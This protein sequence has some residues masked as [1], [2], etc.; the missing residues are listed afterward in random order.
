[1]EVATGL[2]EQ[3]TFELADN[4]VVRLN[5]QSEIYIHFTQHRRIVELRKGQAYFEVAKDFRPFEVRVG[6]AVIH[7]IGTAFDVF[8]RDDGTQ[9]TV[10]EGQVS[11]EKSQPVLSDAI[12]ERVPAV[13]AELS[14]GDQAILMP[15]DVVEM[16]H[17]AD[18]QKAVAWTHDEIQFDRETVATVAAEFNRYNR[19]QI[20]IADPKIAELRITGVFHTYD[21]G[22]FGQFINGLPG[23]HATRGAETM[24][25]DEQPNTAAR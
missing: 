9:V 7:D 23:V 8:R 21:L 10:V 16:K 22:S 6:T 14:A 24:I 3:R 19:T 12:S 18:I 15:S 5:S 25:I 2:G 20:V 1:L 17:K 13:M 11:I 4:T